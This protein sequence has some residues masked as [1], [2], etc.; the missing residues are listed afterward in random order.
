MAYPTLATAP[1]RVDP[2]RHYSIAEWQTIEELTGERYEYHKGKLISVRAMAGGT[3]PH[4]LIG[5]NVQFVLGQLARARDAVASAANG[6]GRRVGCGVYSSDLR[7]MIESDDRYVYPDAAVVCGQPVYDTKVP[8]AVRNPIVVV[9]VVSGSSAAY[10][11]GDK[12]DHYATLESLRD[13][14]LVAQDRPRVEVRSRVEPGA[15]WTI[16]VAEGPDGEAFLSGL[17]AGMPLQEVYRLVE[18]G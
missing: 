7:L 3:G 10:D 16:R 17:E 18:F 15:D 2:K 1:F 6:K 11:A 4:A 12:F 13:Y 9:E 8:T 5:G 14:V